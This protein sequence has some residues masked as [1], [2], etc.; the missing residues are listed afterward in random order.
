MKV[1]IAV[2]KNG[3]VLVEAGGGKGTLHSKG[4]LGNNLGTVKMFSSPFLGTPIFMN[5][6]LIPIS[7]SPPFT[8]IYQDLTL[9]G[10]RANGL[11]HK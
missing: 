11:M 3:N 1:Y 4:L 2:C 5:W 10:V 9:T 6:K 8:V 7:L